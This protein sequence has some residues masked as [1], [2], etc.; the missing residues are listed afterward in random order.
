MRFALR[1]SGFSLGFAIHYLVLGKLLKFPNVVCR[2][3][4]LII[5]LSRE[6]ANIASLLINHDSTTYVACTVKYT[7]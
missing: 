6:W 5:P 1:R 3:G 4:K 2:I 7:A